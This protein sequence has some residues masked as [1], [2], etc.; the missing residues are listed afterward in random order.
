MQAN[1]NNIT[2]QD[3]L[4]A[5]DYF[6][7]S[8]LLAKNE[9]LYH[10]D[11]KCAKKFLLEIERFILS[12]EFHFFVIYAIESAAYKNG[13]YREDVDYRHHIV[14]M[15]RS[16]VRLLD[17]Y[18]SKKISQKIIERHQEGSSINNRL[19]KHLNK[20]SIIVTDLFE[21]DDGLMS[22]Y[23]FIEQYYS[24]STREEAI[25]RGSSSEYVPTKTVNERSD[26]HPQA[27]KT[28]PPYPWRG[29]PEIY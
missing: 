9:Y 22:I 15:F 8:I 17:Y 13:P 7:E 19:R 26:T 18:L 5:I 16:R 4:D 11:R 20:I 24:G 27:K 3:I 12:R 1:N 21:S 14:S 28:S 6:F 25:Y 29:Y 10:L 23:D 2:A